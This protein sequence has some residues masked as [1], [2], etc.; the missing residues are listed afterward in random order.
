MRLLSGYN[1]DCPEDVHGQQGEEES[2][3]ECPDEW[4]HRKQPAFPVM[5]F[6]PAAKCCDS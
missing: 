5:V 3:K 4:A 1:H 6:G 2:N